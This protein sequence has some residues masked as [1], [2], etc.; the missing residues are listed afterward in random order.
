MNV[1]TTDYGINDYWCLSAWLHISGWQAKGPYYKFF[2]NN[3]LKPMDSFG[4]WWNFFLFFVF[5]NAEF[6]RVVWTIN[7]L[8]TVCSEMLPFSGNN[9]N[10]KMFGVPPEHFAIGYVHNDNLPLRYIALQYVIQNNCMNVWWCFL[11]I[12]CTFWRSRFFFVEFT[13]TILSL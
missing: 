12:S 1:L 4:T 10:I 9:Q 6:Y 5:V 2:H 3:V 7:A 8:L 11:M 13:K